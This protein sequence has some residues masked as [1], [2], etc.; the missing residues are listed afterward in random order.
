[1]AHQALDYATAMDAIAHFVAIS[2]YIGAAAFAAA[3]IARPVRAPVR[4]VIGALAAGVAAHLTGLLMAGQR[5]GQLPVSGLGP[6]LSLAGLMVA[7]TLLIAE[8]STRDVT[9]TLIGG[10]LAATV[11]T[12]G[13]V[14]GLPSAS[15]SPG[16]AWLVSHIALSFF[17]IAAFA[18]AAA[19]GM[20]YLLE[21]RELRSRR[22]TA[23]LRFFPPLQTLDRVNHIGILVSSAAL[24]IG[25]VLAATYSIAH[26]TA[27]VAEIV[28]GVTVWLAAT[29]IAFGRVVGGW[30][31]RR[32]ALAASVTFVMIVALY[33]A[34]R[35]NVS[36]GGSFL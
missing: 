15:P 32:A 16:G 6:A 20:M 26:Q 36:A 8:I 12:I 11:T 25:I 9:L 2:C 1:M 14:S 30:Q 13:N 18:T 22:F 27:N 10:P 17:G 21:R 19:A 28:W 5:L 24:T 29:A 3:P 33:V 23:V 4:L 31:A 35:L 7:I 34:V